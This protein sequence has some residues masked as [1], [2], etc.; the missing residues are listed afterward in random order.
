[1][2]FTALLVLLAALAAC[3]RGPAAGS[4]KATPAGSATPAPQ[5]ATQPVPAPGPAFPLR[6]EG[7]GFVDANGRPFAWRGITAFRL[8]EMIARGREQEAAAYLEWA[9]SQQLTVVRVLLMARHLFQL[10]AEDGRAA[11]PR[12]LDLAR[13]RGLAVEVV[14]LADTLD[15]TLDYEAHIREVVRIAAEK[16]NAVIE[17]ANEPGH[18]T[19]DPRVHD[20]SFLQRLADAVPQELVVA[21]GSLEYGAG[22]AA[23]DYAT[24]HVPR[25]EKDWDHVLAIAERADWVAKL[26]KPVVSDEPIGA[27]PE[28]QPGRRD[29][30]PAR[31]AAAAALTRAV[32]MEATFHYEGGLHARIPS[33]READC[34]QAWRSGLE[35]MAGVS[36]DGQFL[37]GERTRAVARVDG[38]R[39]T[40]ARIS[41]E[42]AVLLLIDPP[43]STTVQWADGWK[44]L[45]RRG[46]PGVE[47]IVGGR[48]RPAGKP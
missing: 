33:A 13:A 18:P 30:D 39:A 28:Y 38:P 44:E 12:L 45:R 31:F 2:R 14:T 9:A 29:N 26:Q 37:V 48:P 24:T 16:G 20:A 15:V 11:L 3:D 27:G 5:Q 22:F 25:G 47:L 8:A 36:L 23:A 10:S 17:I 41:A 4:P 32:G 6:V 21:L 34:L 35:L 19:Q 42:H 46:S 7:R 40:F 43:P 1:M